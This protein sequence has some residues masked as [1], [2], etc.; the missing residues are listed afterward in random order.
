[1]KSEVTDQ[2]GDDLTH[3]ADR[4]VLGQKSII[5]SHC[6]RTELSAPASLT[7]QTAMSL[8]SVE[9]V[10]VFRAGSTCSWMKEPSGESA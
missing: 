7:E 8:D 3:P 5:V 9:S 6:T 1:M 4:R 10:E 2:G